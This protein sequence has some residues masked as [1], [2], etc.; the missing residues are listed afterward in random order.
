MVAPFCVFR[1]RLCG[2]NQFEP[3]L[4]ACQ[5]KFVYE[6]SAVLRKYLQFHRLISEFNG[7]NMSM[8]KFMTKLPKPTVVDSVPCVISVEEDDE[9]DEIVVP[10]SLIVLISISRI[11][12]C[13][14][15]N[16]LMQYWKYSHEV[17]FMCDTGIYFAVL[18]VTL[19]VLHCSIKKKNKFLPL[20]ILFPESL[21]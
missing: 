19:L 18:E 12:S 14:T 5:S 16:R 4:D 6:K 2:E 17:S 7:L 21:T 13:S 11:G 15:E 20:H 8:L 1:R 3:V 9:D 10:V